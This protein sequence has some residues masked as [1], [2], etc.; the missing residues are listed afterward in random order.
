MHTHTHTHTNTYKHTHTNTHIHPHAE[1]CQS[2]EDH[3][4]CREISKRW[5][6]FN[7][8]LS[9]VETSEHWQHFIKELI[10]DEVV[11]CK[12]SEHCANRTLIKIESMLLQCFDL[13]VSQMCMQC[14]FQGL[15]VFTCNHYTSS[16]IARWFICWVDCN[17]PASHVKCATER[18]SDMHSICAALKSLNH[19]WSNAWWI[20]IMHP[21][22]LEMFRR[23]L[24]VSM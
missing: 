1:A 14:I 18:F 2:C 23:S 15:A 16:I 7:Q 13:P 11:W 17:S 12:Y 20:D 4:R 8:M 6:S 3:G 24:T 22:K 9:F 10:R 19:V 5:S 21:A